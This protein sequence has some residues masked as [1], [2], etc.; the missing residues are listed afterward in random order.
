M[1]LLRTRGR[2]RPPPLSSDALRRAQWRSLI[3][4]PESAHSQGGR[5]RRVTGGQD[6]G[7]LASLDSGHTIPDPP[8]KNLSC[9]WSLGATRTLLSA[10]ASFFSSLSGHLPACQL[11]YCL[12]PL[13]R[14]GHCQWPCLMASCGLGLCRGEG[15]R[16][17]GGERQPAEGGTAEFPW[18]IGL[19]AGVGERAAFSGITWVV[20]SQG[21]PAERPGM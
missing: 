4:C 19:W 20:L 15:A 12:R 18:T 7:Q 16:A 10:L 3:S 2:C 5:L 21:N 11:A 9:R 8:P 17:G 13:P 14:E 6:S 1:L